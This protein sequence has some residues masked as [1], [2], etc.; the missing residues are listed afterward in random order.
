MTVA[1]EP[2]F[3]SNAVMAITGATY[4][5]LDHWTR[6]GLLR[7]VNALPGSGMQREWRPIDVRA[8]AALVAFSALA[9]IHRAPIADA[10]YDAEHR[11]DARW[12]VVFA[13]GRTHLVNDDAV[14]VT[15]PCWIYPLEAAS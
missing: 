1:T 12:L 13:D 5:Q 6:T 8:V 7:P 10:I 11:S 4:K 3:S 9:Q 15:E 14:R 2:L